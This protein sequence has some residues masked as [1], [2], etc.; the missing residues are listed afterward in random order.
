M[1]GKQAELLFSV[2]PPNVGKINAANCCRSH[3]CSKADGR[4]LLQFTRS[5][6]RRAAARTAGW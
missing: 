1:P 5:P 4:G 2:C 6:G 3:F